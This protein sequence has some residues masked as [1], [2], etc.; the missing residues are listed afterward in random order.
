MPSIAFVQRAPTQFDEPFYRFLSKDTGL[1]STTYYYGTDNS[2]VEHDPEI[3]RTVGWGGDGGNRGYQS[4][5]LPRSSPF[6]FALHVIRARH[7][8]VILGGYNDRHLFSTALL[9]K[10][11]NNPV[12][13]RSDN[14]LPELG[15]SSKL[16][17]AKS[18][19]Y[20][21]MFRLYTTAHPVGNG[22]ES[23]LT[24]F[25]F[26]E[27]ALFRFPYGIDHDWFAQQCAAA[28]RNRN[29]V[30][31]SWGL[32]ANVPVV[33]G[34][35]KFSEREDPLTLVNAMRVVR[36]SQPDAA[37][38]LVGDGPLK[39]EIVEAAAGEVGKSVFLPGYVD[40]NLL[41]SIYAV[42]DLYIHT[43][44]GPWE[45]SVNE[46]LACGLPVVA[47]DKTG[48]ARE[49]VL[50]NK[51]GHTYSHADYQELARLVISATGDSELKSRA[52]RQ[53][54]DILRNWGYAKTVENM[55]DALNFTKNL[56]P[57]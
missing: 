18:F 47:S 52:W 44:S 45:V 40:Y 20:P 23:Y 25:G 33:C 41:P 1:T 31:R 5:F 14:L 46:A 35:M 28:R 50:P 43:A 27:R 22:S 12:G 39:G 48:S 7:D 17:M 15:G 29:E 13:L 55:K 34:V 11:F 57:K 54:P 30:R 9:S 49:L 6:S 21:H 2:H 10:V 53:G 4:V 56:H 51:L 26:K 38:L 24:R 37:L 8:L 32:P 16:W 42:S 36:K 19:I 3:N